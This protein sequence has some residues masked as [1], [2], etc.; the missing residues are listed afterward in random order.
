M[1]I[2]QA[3]ALHQ[4]GKLAEAE[5]LYALH[6]TQAPEDF[7][8]RYLFA[9][10]RYQ[11]GQSDA[12]GNVEAAL[13]LMPDDPPALTLK[14]VLLKTA[15]RHEESLTSMQ[16]AA[17]LEP[18]NGEAQFNLG[19]A[20][21]ELNRPDEAL[22]AFEAALAIKPDAESWYSKGSMLHKLRR[23]AEAV[24]SYDQAVALEPGS[25]EFWNNRGAALESLKRHEDALASFNKALTLKPE[26]AELWYNRATALIG[27]ESHGE[28]LKSAERAL[29]IRPDHLGALSHRGAAL[30]GLNRLPEA[31]AALNAALTL[32]P[33]DPEALTNRGITLSRLE[34]F[35]EAMADFEKALSI[36]PRYLH[37]LSARGRILCKIG[38]VAEGFA[39]LQ[40]MAGEL[41]SQE[42]DGRDV[43][44]HRIRHDTEQRAHRGAATPEEFYL[45]EAE[46]LPGPAIN[47]VN[48]QDATRQ[49][50]ENRPQLV[51]IDNLLT[52]EAL[53]KLRRY[54]LESSIWKRNYPDGYL[55]AMPE[56]GFAPPL[57]AQIA[58]ELSTAFPAIFGEHTLHMWW[59][60]KYDSA[61]KGI[62]VHA[63]A[64]AV[65]VN[66]W[67]TPDEANRN[68]D[69]G[70]LV[71]WDVSAPE[72]WSFE[73]YN[74]DVAA[75]RRFLAGAGAKPVTVP[76][77]ANRAVIFDSDLF[78]ETDQIEFKEGYLNRRINVTLLYGRRTKHAN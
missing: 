39:L 20:L 57:L 71:V 2:Q 32:A 43:P 75:A 16:R 66:F 50:H 1:T 30:Q 10:L 78:H 7:K 33:G 26:S 73:Q 38:R 58:E 44:A 49:W 77:R 9:V 12:L 67:I 11:Q 28:A 23:F 48:T 25:A 27:M 53:E 47:P 60:F 36:R 51:V 37:A 34:R 4:E 21:A 61:L 62:A 18:G 17:M 35:D 6:L 3:I 63:D 14:G 55:G 19:V 15:G 64:A 29:A 56:S 5:A 69:N 54:C 46:R 13:G 72:D 68:P 74:G 52:P 41:Y 65:N 59:G 24:T 45:G 40:G 70:G 8:A 22:V 42:M 76:Y 31:L